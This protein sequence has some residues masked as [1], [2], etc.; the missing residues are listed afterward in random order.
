VSSDQAMYAEKDHSYF[1]V[2][3][4]EI[5]PLLPERMNRVLEIGCGAGATLKWIRG[6]RSVGYAVGIE[7]FA[8]V[9]KHAETIFD[10]LLVGNVET[11]EFPET[12]FD[13]IIALDVLEHLV[14]P[15]SVVKRLHGVLAPGGVIIASIPNIGHYSVSGPLV[16]SGRW[17]YANEGLLDRTH[18]RF[19][20]RRTA[21]E[22]LT[23]SGLVMDR[24]EYTRYWHGRYLSKSRLYL[25]RILDRLLPNHLSGFQFLIRVK[26]D[27]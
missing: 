17:N 19:F 2:A 18:L 7:M 1:G 27:A 9:A 20:T 23:C 14:D 8:E 16:L 10:E 11:M 13:V 12:G 6:Q 3:R 15:W 21:I 25:V 22:L 5:A 24:I 26:S 4:T